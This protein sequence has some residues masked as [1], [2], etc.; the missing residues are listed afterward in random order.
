MDDSIDVSEPNKTNSSDDDVFHDSPNSVIM[1]D[2][3]S[4]TAKSSSTCHDLLSNPSL[5]SPIDRID[6]IIVCPNNTCQVSQWLQPVDPN[7]TPPPPFSQNN[8]PILYGLTEQRNTNRNFSS[9]EDSQGSNDVLQS[10]I[11]WETNQS[12]S[13]RPYLRQRK[14]LDYYSL[15][16]FGKGGSGAWPE[17]GEERD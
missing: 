6:S 1:Q 11:Q 3:R 14:P 12:R 10:G 2:L 15:H 16:H 5:Q 8:Y 7:D 4:P 9:Q 17:N 13:S